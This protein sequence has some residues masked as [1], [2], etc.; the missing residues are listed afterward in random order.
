[1]LVP[2]KRRRLDEPIAVLL[3]DLVPQN[4]FDRHLEAKLDLSFFRIE[5]IIVEDE[6]TRRLNL[7]AEIVCD[8][9]KAVTS[10]QHL[11]DLFDLAASDS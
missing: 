5:P 6:R 1:M 8:R 4:H 2:A 10:S 11:R 9:V 3:E 7:K